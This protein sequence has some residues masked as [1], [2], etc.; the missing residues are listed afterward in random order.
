ML[1]F[2]AAEVM[3]FAAL[4]SAYLIVSSGFSDWPP[5]D[6]PRLPVITTAF[7]TCALLLSGTMIFH[8][9]LSLTRSGP[10]RR[11]SRL[12]LTAIA[13]GA[14]F[15]LFQGFEWV[16]LIHFGLTMKSSTYGSF[17]YLII[18]THALHAVAA[19][20][21][22]IVV[23]RRLRRNALSP[24]SFW[25]AQV[26]WYFVVGVWPILYILIYLDK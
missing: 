6:Q 22:L 8:A 11:T 7:N 26:F 10:G 1:I 4:I 15:V 14:I 3:F 12:L 19:L 25:A 20:L 13:L 23:Y 24:E 2:V 17:F 16:R 21:V 9:N 18:G 5:P